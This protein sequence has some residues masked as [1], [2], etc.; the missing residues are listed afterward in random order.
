M[1]TLFEKEAGNADICVIEGV[2][3]LFDGLGPLTTAA[4][5]VEADCP[6]TTSNTEQSNCF[7]T[8]A[9]EQKSLSTPNPSKSPITPSITPSTSVA[10]VV[11]GFVDFDPKLN[12]CGV[13]I[14]KV[15]SETHYQLIK[16]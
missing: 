3:G 5:D 12:I 15:A 8:P 4:T 11:K 9:L 16:V 10:A 14:N 6:F 2:M 1:K 13:I 7:A